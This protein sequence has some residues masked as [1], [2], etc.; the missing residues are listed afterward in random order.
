MVIVDSALKQR[1]AA[2]NPIRVGLIGSGFMGRGIVHQIMNY[3]P[4]MRVAAIAN[5]TMKTG[6]AAYCEAGIDAVEAVETV[7][8]LETAIAKSRHPVTTDARLLCQA[9]GID[10]L[11]DATG[12]VEFGAHVA[13]EAIRHGKHLSLMNA[14]LDAT[15]GPI[16]KVHAD[17]AGVVLTGCDGDQPAMQM[18]LCTAS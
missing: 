4:G 5:R 12:A 2:G 17:R 9:E 13:M 1:A 14:E 8:A 6:R 18:N 15:V 11:V 10:V 3:V 7:S 16:L